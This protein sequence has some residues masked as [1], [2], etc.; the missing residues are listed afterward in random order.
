MVRREPAAS[1]AMYTSAGLREGRNGVHGL[2]RIPH[3]VQLAASC[4]FPLFPRHNF[5]RS[6]LLISNIYDNLDGSKAQTLRRAAVLAKCCDFMA[7]VTRGWLSLHHIAVLACPWLA[8][9]GALSI[10]LCNSAFG[11]SYRSVAPAPPNQRRNRHNLFARFLTRLTCVR[12]SRYVA[13]A[14]LPQDSRL[15]EAYGAHM[16][17]EAV[18]MLQRAPAC[19]RHAPAAPCPTDAPAYV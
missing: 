9:R 17:R 5:L 8:G 16:G 3:W 7:S 15:C 4:P 12:K 13:P 19:K 10:G 1:D 14:L 2:E 18:R 6:Q 11:Q